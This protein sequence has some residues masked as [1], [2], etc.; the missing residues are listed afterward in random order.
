[1][2]CIANIQSLILHLTRK[3]RSKAHIKI[4]KRYLSKIARIANLDNPEDVELALAIARDNVSSTTKGCY[5]S[6]Y[7]N[8]CNFFKIK[9]K[10]PKY[11]RELTG[12]QPPTNEKIQ[13]RISSTRSA[14]IWTSPCFNKSIYFCLL[15]ASASFSSP[16]Y[17]AP[18]PIIPPTIIKTPAIKIAI[19]I[20][21]SSPL[22]SYIIKRVRHYW[23]IIFSSKKALLVNFYHFSAR[24]PKQV[25]SESELI[26]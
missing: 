5:V 19:P 15:R 8:Y 21:I 18:P 2:G 3:S 7:T 4:S 6:I 20:S 10:K 22:A 9:W 26:F 14:R 17:I 12:I 24:K 1:M 16:A 25:K 11:L 23:Y 13:I